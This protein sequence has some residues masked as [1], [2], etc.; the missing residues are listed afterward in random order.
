MQEKKW[1]WPSKK[2]KIWFKY[3]NNAVF[4]GFFLQKN[5]FQI[6]ISLADM[7]F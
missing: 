4:F 2:I 3:N 6:T 7:T 1:K 5:D